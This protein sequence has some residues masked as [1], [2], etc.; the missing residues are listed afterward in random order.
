[1][2]SRAD[3]GTFM[4]DAPGTA[5]AS[6]SG[7]W[8]QL[9]L[10]VVC[11]MLIANLQ[12]GWTLF[13]EPMRKAH[14]WHSS[15][16]QIAFSL[17]IALETW[18][19]PA[20]GW[21]VDA[22]GPR[23]GPRLA[24]AAGGVLVA[25]GWVLNGW[26]ETLT[27]LYIGSALAG[28]GGGAIYA[29][30]VGNAVKWFPDRRGLAVGLTAAGFGAGAAVTVVPIRAM[31]LSQGYASTFVWFGIGQGLI[32][33][34][35]AAWLRAPAQ[36]EIVT[37]RRP[38][39]RQA[40][41]SEPPR[42]VLASPLFWLLYVMFV[43]VSGSGLM[44]SAQIALV[45][46]QFGVADTT[47][48]WGASTLTIALIVDNVMNGTARPCFGWLS[49]RI[50]REITMAIAFS[51]GGVSYW[52][53]GAF[54]TTPWGFVICAGLIFLTWGEIFS[55]FPSTCTDI[56]GP[57]FATV[58]ASLLYTAKGASAWL[59][60]FANVA[61]SGGH[62]QTVLTMTALANFVVVVLALF[63]LRPARAAHHAAAVRALAASRA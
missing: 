19:T 37:L 48:L 21:F 50:G 5:P 24:I 31:I 17:F 55:L 22:V 61:A 29:T 3:A 4:N 25:A 15:E 36:G 57:G 11:M 12:Y 38:T 35:I 28:L 41:I 40:A 46:R 30:C 14:G 34:A 62:W 59:V 26:A 43:L 23:N 54:G 33:L 60:P 42:R 6:G 8:W 27:W 63:V 18:F 58:N 32:V 39:V 51:L 7:R 9:A 47:L 2:M 13:V 53:L 56:F 44:A 16:I 49:D 52:M 10:G 1:M 45:A 20:A